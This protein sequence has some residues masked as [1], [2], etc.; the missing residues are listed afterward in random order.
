MTNQITRMLEPQ[1]PEPDMPE[2]LVTEEPGQHMPHSES[3]TPDPKSHIPHPKDN[4]P[5][6]E[7]IL[8]QNHMA[9]PKD[10]M[11]EPTTCPEECVGEWE[12]DHG[13]DQSLLDQ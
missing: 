10:L 9:E 2:P 1:L 7:Y 6:Q 5:D 8:N 3:H 13:T 12:I 4:V 11:Q